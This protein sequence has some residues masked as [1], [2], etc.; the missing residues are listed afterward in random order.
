MVNSPLIGSVDHYLV[1]YNN[2]LMA[3]V[4]A[5]GT[6]GTDV[7]LPPFDP[8]A[9]YANGTITVTAVHASSAFSTPNTTFDV[10]SLWVRLEGEYRNV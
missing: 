3:N 6:N 5:N 4:S 10:T 1:Y 2:V 9:S 7:V 8:T